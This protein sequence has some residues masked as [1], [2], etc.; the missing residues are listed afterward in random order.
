MPKLQMLHNRHVGKRC[1]LIA[2]GPSLNQMNLSFLKNEITIGLNKIYLG[3]HKFGFYPRYYVAINEKVIQQ[4]YSEIKRMTSVKFIAKRSSDL[5]PEDALT[6]HIDT[7]DPPRRF[8]EDINDGVHEGG[9][10]TFAALQIAFY[11]GFQEV[12]IIGMDHRFQFTGLPNESMIMEG[13][14]PNHFSSHYFKNGQAW[15]NPDLNQSEESYMLAK[16]IYE[17]HN[18]VIIDATVDGACSIFKK[19][20]YLEY[21]N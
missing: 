6:Y 10:V 18:K 13:D 12:I 3:L 20:N 11:L 19:R 2:N 21:L 16:T 5:L 14:D 8:C 7:S 1:F 15:D 17:A 4:S 9:T